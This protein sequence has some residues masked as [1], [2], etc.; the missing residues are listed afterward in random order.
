M[1]EL[2][3]KGQYR[4]LFA[5]YRGFQSVRGEDDS[6]RM[7]F[8]LPAGSYATALLNEFVAEGEIAEK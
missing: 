4:V 5:P 8:S 1:P 6:V 2:N 7:Q 3:C